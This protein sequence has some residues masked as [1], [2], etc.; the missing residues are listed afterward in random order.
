MEIYLGLNAGIDLWVSFTDTY[1]S[2]FEVTIKLR[3]MV[4]LVRENCKL[5]SGVQ[6]F[7]MQIIDL[8]HCALKNPP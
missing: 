2:S 5:Q 4:K 7:R 6:D 8:C 3:K 1:V